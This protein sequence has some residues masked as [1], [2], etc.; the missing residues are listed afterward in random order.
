[1]QFRRR[2]RGATRLQLISMFVAMIVFFAL[3]YTL[4]GHMGNHGLWLAFIAYLLTR[5]LMQ[6]LLWPRAT[7][8]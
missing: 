7:S 5:G 6:T 4:H 8:A 1:M 3:Y 2:W